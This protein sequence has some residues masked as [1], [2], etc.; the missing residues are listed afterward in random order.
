MNHIRTAIIIFNSATF[1]LMLVF[2]TLLWNIWTG[3]LLTPQEQKDFLAQ[4]TEVRK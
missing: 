1:V 4:V 2:A 3:K